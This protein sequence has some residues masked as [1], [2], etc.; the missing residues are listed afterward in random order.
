MPLI[1][2]HRCSVCVSIENSPHRPHRSRDA[3]CTMQGQQR[4]QDLDRCIHVPTHII[5][6]V[7]LAL[8]SMHRLNC[9]AHTLHC[10]HLQR[11]P[12]VHNSTFDA[13]LHEYILDVDSRLIASS[14]DH[15]DFGS[16]C[17]QLYLSTIPM[18]LGSV[19]LLYQILGTSTDLFWLLTE[20]I[21]CALLQQ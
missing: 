6:T 14:Q 15:L 12:G 7:H 1:R 9:C 5:I 11:D 10:R 17:L 18:Y 21:F 13:C 4:L 19:H 20:R 8:A 3:N 2:T 16:T